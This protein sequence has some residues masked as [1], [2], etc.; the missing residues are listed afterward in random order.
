[1]KMMRTIVL[2]AAWAV[3]TLTANSAETWWGYWTPRQGVEAKGSLER[4]ANDV[5]IYV[6]RN[7]PQLAGSTVQA[8]RFYIGDKTAVTRLRVWMATDIFSWAWEQPDIAVQ[9]VNLTDIV[10]YE[11]DGQMMTVTFDNPVT[12]PPSGAYIGYTVTIGAAAADHPCNLYCSTSSSGTRYGCYFQWSEM[13][14]YIG[15]TALQALVSNENLAENAAI[16]SNFGTQ[17]LS[18]GTD[19]PLN[20]TLTQTGT[21]PIHTIGYVLSLNATDLPE[22]QYTLPADNSPTTFLEP[23]NVTLPIDLNMAAAAR[24]N[25]T[26]RITHVNGQPNADQSATASA[27]GNILLLQQP[28]LRRSVMEEFTGTWCTW[29]PRGIVAMRKLEAQFADRFIGIAAHFDDPMQIPAY[30][31]SR[32]KRM[33]SGL[34]NSVIDRTTVCDPYMGTTTEKHFHADKDIERALAQPAVA[35]ITVAAQWDKDKTNVLNVG[36]QT[37][38]WYHETET[39]P[40]SLALILLENGMK[41]EGNDWRQ[42]NRYAEG[43]SGFDDADMAE[44]TAAPHYITD[45][46]YDHVPIDC[47][48]LNNG[49]S[50]SISLPLESGKP[51]PFSYAWDVSQNT[52]LQDKSRLSVVA[53]L[54]NTQSGVIENAAKVEVQSAGTTGITSVPT[55]R[56]TAAYYTIDGR[57]LAHPQ[58]GLN[59]VRRTDGTVQKIIVK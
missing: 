38:F 7:H 31:T 15:N 35:D 43:N 37:T 40:Y 28:A 39:A 20:V 9:E 33:A 45:I 16:P 11:T 52:L 4:G 21:Q 17:V 29:C 51:Q 41:G 25:A 34:P 32:V 59:I 30:K 24:Y 27:G 53:L 57:P 8:V 22:Q 46:A 36:V 14:K 49:I 42:V 18:R 10:D 58:R 54:L 50:G 44:F 2:I 48:E 3:T 56:G 19:C 23:Q 12:L 6:P 47:V 26:L 13:Y 1:M 55:D 5:A